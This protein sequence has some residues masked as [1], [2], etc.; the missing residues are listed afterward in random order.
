VKA[1]IVGEGLDETTIRTYLR[2]EGLADY[3]IPS[4]IE[5]VDSIDRNSIGKYIKRGAM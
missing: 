3:K 1:V 5:F 4:L 2:Q